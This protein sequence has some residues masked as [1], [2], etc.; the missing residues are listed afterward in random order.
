MRLFNDVPHFRTDRNNLAERA[1]IGLGNILQLAA[2]THRGAQHNYRANQHRQFVFTVQMHRRDFHQEILPVDDDMFGMGIRRRAFQPAHEVE[3]V[4][5]ARRVMV[6]QLIFTLP[7][8]RAACRVGQFNFAF[9]IQGQHGFRQRF[10]Q[11]AKRPMLTLGR[12]PWHR[13][14]VFHALDATDFSHKTAE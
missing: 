4:D 11:R 10:K 14:N 2:H 1:G 7:E 5:K 8:Q 9:H 3:S 12:H 13:A 6:T